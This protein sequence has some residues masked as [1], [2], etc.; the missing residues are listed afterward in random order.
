MALSISILALMSAFL[1]ALYA[2]WASVQAQRAN[3]IGR[4][5]ALLAS[6]QH[7]LELMDTQA[8]A[9]QVHRASPSIA[10]AA[11]AAYDAL[12]EKLAAALVVE[13][14]EKLPKLD[15]FC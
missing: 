7:Y 9:A 14:V 8:S 1:T 4:L 6:R 13:A 10:L 12:D 3:D 11:R 15:R 5:N 2:R